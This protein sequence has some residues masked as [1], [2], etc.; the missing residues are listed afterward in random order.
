MTSLGNGHWNPESYDARFEIFKAT[1]LKS[2]DVTIAD[3]S[4]KVF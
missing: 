2:D 1:M 3:E 4:F